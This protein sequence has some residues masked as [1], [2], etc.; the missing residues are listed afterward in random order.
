MS[1]INDLIDSKISILTECVIKVNNNYFLLLE[2][3]AIVY[4][5][6]IA[7]YL[8]NNQ[9]KEL[10]NSGVEFCIK[11]D[12]IPETR[13]GIDV[14]YKCVLNI[15][16]KVFLVYD[17]AYITEPPQIHEIILFQTQLCPVI[18]ACGT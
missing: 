15:D 17:I 5:P 14:M 16:K 12:T 2:I 1:F 10:L 18:Q 9:A 13:P 7:V 6:I 3:D 4:Q 11:S 8:T